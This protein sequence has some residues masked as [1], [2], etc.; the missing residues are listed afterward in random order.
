MTREAH[1]GSLVPSVPSVCGETNPEGVARRTQLSRPAGVPRMNPTS[2]RDSTCSKHVPRTVALQKRGAVPALGRIH[3]R[4]RG[5]GENSRAGRKNL[6]RIPRPI[7][8]FQI[9]EARCQARE[10]RRDHRGLSASATPEKR[11]GRPRG[12][13]G[14]PSAL[15]AAPRGAC[16]AFPQ[17]V[18]RERPRATQTPP[19]ARW[20]KSYTK[21]ARNAQGK[22]LE[23][24]SFPTKASARP[25]PGRSRYVE[26]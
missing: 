12:S 11:S 7:G 4:S 8:R 6:A 21:L 15:P 1:C 10:I 5:C 14:R 24:D 26:I 17:D 16:P 25:V 22:C 3:P 19:E 9:A 13:R 2:R 18:K 23:I 20:P